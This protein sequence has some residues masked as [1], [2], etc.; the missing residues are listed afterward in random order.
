MQIKLKQRIPVVLRLF[1]TIWACMCFFSC[2]DNYEYDNKEPD[3][4]GSSIYESLEQDG[5]F[6]YFLRL[7][8]DLE[9]KEVLS[10]T[11]SK[12]LFPARDDAFE[13]FFTSNPYGISSY[14]DMS[15]A[16]KRNIMN[17]SIV[18][19]AYLSYMLSNISGS[20]AEGGSNLGEGLALRRN[21]TNTYLDSITFLKDGVLFENPYWKRFSSKGLYLVDNENP[22]KIVHFTQP[23]MRLQ[24]ITDED[25]SILNN[26]KTYAGDDIYINGVKIIEKDIICKNGY[27]HVMEDVIVPA[28]NMAQVIRDN[29]ETNLFSKLLNKFCMPYYDEYIERAVHNYYNGSSGGLI[30]QS[31]SV[32]VKR[33]F[34]STNFSNDQSGNSLESHGLLYFDPT[35]NGYGSEVD[36]GSMFVPTDQAMNEYINGSKGRYLKDAYGS[37]ENVP[38]PLL[39]LFLK[40]HQK[41][42]FINSLPHAWAAL[43]DESSFEMN[44][45]KSDIKKT[46]I[47]NNGAIYISNSVYPP[48]DYQSVYG[49]TMTSPNTLVMNTAIHNDATGMKFFMYLRSMENMYNLLVPTDEAFLN[50]REPISW[51]KGESGREIWSFYYVSETNKVHA[52]VYSADAS[53]NKGAF[54]R[55]LH[56]NTNQDIIQNRL[57]D[58]LDMHIVVGYKDKTTGNMWGYIDDGNTQYAQTKSGTT[59]KVSGIGNNVTVTGAGDIEENISPAQIVTDPS[60]GLKNVYDADNGRTYFID[61]ILHDP[62]KSTYTVLGEHSE[63]KVF[64][65]MLRGNDQVFTYFESDPDIVPI[66]DYKRTTVTS[67]LGYVVN[68]FNNFR[69]TLFVPTEEALKRAF[70]EDKNLFMWED[71]ANETDHDLK[72]QKTLYL[73]NFLKFHFMDNS[74]FIDGNSFS[75]TRYETAARNESGKFHKLSLSSSGNNLEIK[76]EN[77]SKK[78]NVIK[79]EGLYNLMSRDFIVN[80]ANYMNATKIESSSRAVIHLID[81]ALRIE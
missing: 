76:G 8:N 22:A 7:I 62:S 37:W 27:I 28:K 55:H 31:D 25:F 36:M 80:S 42:S 9:Y 34:N 47:A 78:V 65:D 23:N 24:G 51:A 11:G 45:S 13:R 49:S 61:K 1:I 68:S 2:E 4:L 72:K 75:D 48:V 58:I 59:L 21:T 53:G 74:V 29:G 30:P 12:T 41:R 66:F 32:F 79:S 69:Y 20:D 56:G 6:T 60:T 14:E 16:Q 81:N 73:L 46:Y 5:N 40:N 35:D 39:A 3:F 77:S 44:I 70:D 38:T 57:R 71:I 18:N 50:Y 10:R 15:P 52:D 26:G 43:T 64:F 33:Y 54:L 63:Y 19:M 17:V 67:G